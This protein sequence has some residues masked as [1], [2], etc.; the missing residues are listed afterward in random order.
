LDKIEVSRKCFKIKN[1]RD[2]FENCPVI[3][4]DTEYNIKADI[5]LGGVRWR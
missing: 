2:Y 4:D 5:S 3:L 1:K